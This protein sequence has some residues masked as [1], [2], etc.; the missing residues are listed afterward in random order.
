[1]QTR[2]GK[3]LA[4]TGAVFVAGAFVAAVLVPGGMGA[5]A[6][7]APEAGPLVIEKMGSLFAGG[8][9]ITAPGAFDP[10]QYP[11]P[12]AGQTLHV[13][14]VYAQF[15]IPPKAR[16]LPLVMWHGCLSTAWESTPDNRE[17]YQSI[18]VRRGWGVYIIDQPRQGRA[19]KSSEGITITPTPNEQNS[20]NSFRLGI[21]PN[22]FPNTQ[23]PHDPVSMDHFFRQG[24]AAHGP[25]NRILFVNDVAALL[26]RIGPAVLVT[27][28]ASGILGWLTA[29]QS[30]NVK[31]IVAYEPTTQVYPEG[32]VPPDVPT[33]FPALATQLA[34]PAVAQADFDKLT[35]I[36]ILIVFGDNIPTTPQNF[37]N[38][39]F[40]RVVLAR[41]RQFAETLRRR[42]GDVMFL[43]LPEIGIYGNTHFAF[44]DLNNV[45]IADLMSQYLKEKGLDKREEKE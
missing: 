41:A 30:P 14:H 42:G 5:K 34:P 23:F 8:T 9:V 33:P 1:M 31:G 21:W 18:F 25:A 40:H 15:H 35:K 37:G 43:H 29:I 2:R 26:D 36:P 24:G 17:G 45:Q 3:F 27:H 6:E 11:T 22:F 19:G 44:T 13:D 39:D 32:E 10:T 38:V 7:K 20:F 16:K 12:P 28:S 4:S